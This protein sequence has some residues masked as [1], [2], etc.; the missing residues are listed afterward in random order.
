MR[1][2]MV[3]DARERLQ[4]AARQRAD[5]SGDVRSI[6]GN[7]DLFAHSLT[8]RRRREVPHDH[9]RAIIAD[10]G[11]AVRQVSQRRVGADS[12]EETG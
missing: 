9:P 6:N 8:S 2:S 11:V 3:R 4:R 7:V 10:H 1:S 5:L 12:I